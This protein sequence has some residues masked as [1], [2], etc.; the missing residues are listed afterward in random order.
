MLQELVSEKTFDK[1]PKILLH[2]IS[3]EDGKTK[4][5]LSKSE[6]FTVRL[7]VRSKNPFH[8]SLL[9]WLYAYSE[10]A[11]LP[12]L[13]FPRQ[14]LP[15]FTSQVLEIIESI[16]FGRTLS[17]GEIAEKAGSPR[18]CRAVGSICRFN[19]WPLFIP[20]HRVLHKT[21]KVGKYAFGPSIKQSI[22]EF[23]GFV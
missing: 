10:K 8:D 4:I 23:E 14:N 17:Y 1:G 7:A 12:P 16:P 3:S 20:C 21:E 18:A 19:A 9:D 13:T 5:H 11:K 2:L 22:L 15:P 6:L